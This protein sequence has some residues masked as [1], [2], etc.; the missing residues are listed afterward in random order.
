[1]SFLLFCFGGTGILT[2]GLT[3]ARQT[4]LPLEPLLQPKDHMSY[5]R[6]MLGKFQGKLCAHRLWTAVRPDPLRCRVVI[7][8]LSL[9]VFPSSP[10]VPKGVLV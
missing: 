4:P 6:R 8:I 2:Q 9:P 1:M 10:Q 3:V 7:F 5:L